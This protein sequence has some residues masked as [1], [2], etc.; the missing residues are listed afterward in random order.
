MRPQ[1]PEDSSNRREI[2][3]PS[4]ESLLISLSDHPRDLVPLHPSQLSLDEIRRFLETAGYPSEL[5]Q[6]CFYRH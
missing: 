5:R 6:G 4:F 2:V 1:H 3:P